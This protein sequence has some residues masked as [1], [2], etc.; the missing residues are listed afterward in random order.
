MAPFSGNS[1]AEAG[2]ESGTTEGC[3]NNAAPQYCIKDN[4][5]VLLFQASRSKLYIFVLR[6]ITHISQWVS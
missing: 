1:V 2:L 4:K 3:R 5:T 6:V